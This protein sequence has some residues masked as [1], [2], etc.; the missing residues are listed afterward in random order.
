MP[1]LMDILNSPAVEAL[2]PALLGGAGAALSSPRLAGSRGAVGRG[3][4]GAGEGLA[5]GMQT[6]QRQQQ[7]TLEQQKA[8]QD[9]GYQQLLNQHQSVQNALS[10]DDLDT[11][12]AL[13][14]RFKQLPQA[15]QNQFVTADNWAKAMGSQIVDQMSAPA[16]RQHAV[17]MFKSPE[18][19][20]YWASQGYTDPSQLPTNPTV[21]T[22]LLKDYKPTTPEDVARIAA[23]KAQTSEAQATTTKTQQEMVAENTWVDPKTGKTSTVNAGEVGPKGTVRKS[24]YAK[25]KGQWVSIGGTPI[26]VPEGVDPPPS[27]TP[28]K[29][30][31]PGRQAVGKDPFAD[32]RND[33]EI[34]KRLPSADDAGKLTF[35]EAAELRNK[36]V[37][38]ATPKP[39]TAEETENLKLRNEK[40]QSDITKNEGW[41]VSGTTASKN[42]ADGS[43]ITMPVPKGG[44]GEAISQWMSG[45]TKATVIHADGTKETVDQVSTTP[46]TPPKK[47]WGTK[48]IVGPDGRKWDVSD[49]GEAT[50]AE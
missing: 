26:Y 45:K 46:P 40:L 35:K 7:L 15:Q 27:A 32:L 38:G 47:L 12:T 30:P 9:A 16:Q 5:S 8:Q 13:E 18:G 44:I 34:A 14:T 17:Q 10:Q 48:G 3:I 19:K 37:S 50:P 23:L 33:P 36:A 1:G 39:K 24:D 2:L 22:Q 4:M 21:L 25:S 6:A 20:A 49:T 31:D 11:R 29:P 28:F 42:L 41:K 43:V